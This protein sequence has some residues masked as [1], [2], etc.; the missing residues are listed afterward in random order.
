M[1]YEFYTYIANKY[2][3]ELKELPTVTREAKIFEYTCREI[4]IDIWDTDIIGGH[5]GVKDGTPYKVENPKKFDYTKVLTDED[6][7]IRIELNKRFFNQLDFSNGH[8]CADYGFIINNGLKAYEAKILDEKAKPCSP[9]KA[10]MLDAMLTEINAVKDYAMR[11]SALAG[12][13]NTNGQ[14]RLERIKNALCRVPYEPARDLF[15][16]MASVWII[17]SVVPMSDGHW[18]SISIGRMDQYLYPFYLDAIKSGISK[19][20]VKGYFKNLF[21]F[22]ETYGDGACALNIGG[23]DKDG[24]DLMNDLSRVI[25]EVEKE[26]LTA[27]PIFAVRI[28]DKTP[29][30][31]IDE[32]IDLKLFAIGQPTF[33]GEIPCRKALE[34]R[35]VP[36]EDAVDFTVN[37]CMGIYMVGEE[38]AS[39]WGFVCNMHLPLELAVNG[40]TGINDTLPYESKVEYKEPTNLDELI[41]LYEA[42]LREL[43]SVCMPINRKNAY[44]FA[45]NR[46]NP[47][48]SLIT[49]GCIESGLDRSVG[50]K[51]N[52]ETVETFALANTADAICAI[53]TLVFGQKKYTLGQ[54]IEAARNDYEGYTDILRDIK[55]CKKYGQNDEYANGIASRL[56]DMVASLCKE[57]DSGNVHFVPS[58]HTLDGN[59]WFGTKL[60]STLDGRLAHTPIAKNAGPSN[61]V[62]T[63]DPTS[64]V[65]SAASINQTLFDGGQPIDVY[66]DRSTL[67]AK[68]GR[69]KIKALIKT[70]FMLDGLQFQVNS[71]DIDLLEKAYENPQ[72]YPNLI[73]RIGGYS[74]RFNW[75]PKVTMREFIDR[76]KKDSGV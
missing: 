1:F 2:F 21:V 63:P 60:Y 59:V 46:P 11:F 3:D 47:L 71:I 53:D 8:I 74:I 22:L 48:T 27:S 15:E 19:D 66:F 32:C 76:F 18:A 20:E 41:A 30:D 58:L 10:L 35:G 36:S 7:R 62:R 38:I 45:A 34:H 6:S 33:Y 67:E 69:D 55:A 72:D 29:E 61:D 5:Y 56:T 16:A 65:L 13:M 68:D 24:N 52:T 4:P 50:A 42:Y 31:I 40:G 57:F 25:I 23:M 9:E 26:M 49:A 64:L 51:Y 75:L 17:H 70:Y 43:F 54:L 39:M 28:N 44:E 73:V 12:E 37:S 14:S